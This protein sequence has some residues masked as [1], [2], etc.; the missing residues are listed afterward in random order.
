LLGDGVAGRVGYVQDGSTR[1]DHRIDKAEQIF[2]IGP[3]GVH[4]VV[5]DVVDVL[6]CNAAAAVPGGGAVEMFHKSYFAENAYQGTNSCLNCHGA[7][8]DDAVLG[9]DANQAWRVAAMA[10]CAKW[11]YERALA[12]CREAEDLVRSL[13]GKA[14]SSVSSK[15]DYLVVGSS[16]GSKRDKAEALGVTLLTEEAFLNLLKE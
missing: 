8:G 10:D 1:S 7:V 13:G 2:L 16:P 9:V 11:D 6:D 15:T 14:A 4:R 3:A 5:L 12:F